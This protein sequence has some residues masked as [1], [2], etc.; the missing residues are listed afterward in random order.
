MGETSKE[1]FERGIKVMPGGVNSPA[2]AFGAVGGEP[3]FFRSA[4]GNRLYSEDGGEY[5]DY[6]GSW[7]PFLLG[8]GHPAVTEAL[9]EQV[10]LSTSFGAPC[11]VEVE[12]AELLTDAIPGLDMVRLVSS[13]TEA[14]MS[15]L[16]VARGYTG[17]DRVVKFEGCYHGHG[18]S[19][20]ISAGSGL[21]THGVP[22]SPG[23]TTGT[24]ADTILAPFNDV[25]ALEK[26]FA[27][28]GESI[29]CVIIEPI[30]GNMGVIPSD[31][32]FL[33]RL[34]ELCS[35]HGVLLIFDEVM[36]GFRVAFGGA[37]ELYG[38]T[39]DLVTYGKII[40]GG[41]PVGAYGGR[42]EVMEVVSPVGPVY[43]AGTLSGNPLA[44]R[45]GLATLRTLQEH[46][47]YE[48]LERQGAALQQG[49]QSILEEPGMPD[50]RINRVG[51]MI[52]LFFTDQEVTSFDGAVS[53]D[54]RLFARFFHGM[55]SSSIYLPPSQF[56]AWFLS[57]LH[58][59]EDI[60]GTI[61]AARSVLHSIGATGPSGDEQR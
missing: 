50:G 33:Q 8:H 45:A 56:E 59:D 54:T 13:G 37:A 57:A 49:L 46:P 24:A 4:R 58:N 55:L 32:E 25:E 48:Q 47:P 60:A 22:S 39:P 12:L 29:A 10:D 40:G 19:F 16:R 30:A 28:E 42:R 2:R 36:T 17:R 52:T 18:D 21:L 61:D 51:S 26:I 41:L 6:V 34:R 38:I 1:L 14:T 3:I 20:L 23:V 5:L 53:S 7:G 35:E 9:H 31:P 43:Q 11:R 27:T 44:V 15:A